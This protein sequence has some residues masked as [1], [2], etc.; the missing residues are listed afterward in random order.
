MN[1]YIA[2]LVCAYIAFNFALAKTFSIWSM[3]RMLIIG[4][5]VLVIFLANIFCFPAWIIKLI[6][7]ELL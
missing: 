2:A 3:K 4:Q 5:N 6:E 7:R 1:I